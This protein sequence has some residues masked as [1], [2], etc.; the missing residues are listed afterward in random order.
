MNCRAV[1][2]DGWIQI[3]ILGVIKKIEGKFGKMSQT[4]GDVHDFLGMHIVFKKEKLEISMKKHIQRVFEQFRD[5]VTKNAALPAKH[6][7]F[8]V[9]EDSKNLDKDRAKN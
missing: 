8:N 4:R 1:K 5:E 2:L 9:W 7:L 3:Y 6:Y